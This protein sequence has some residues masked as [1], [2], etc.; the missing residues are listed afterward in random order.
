MVPPPGWSELRCFFLCHPF[1]KTG[2]L[3]RTHTYVDC[4][5]SG[6]ALLSAIPRRGSNQLVCTISRPF[7]IGNGAIW[8]HF[9]LEIAQTRSHQNPSESVAHQNTLKTKYFLA[10]P[11][12]VRLRRNSTEFVRIRQNS[13]EFVG[14][15]RGT[16]RPAAC[17][18]CI[19]TLAWPCLCELHSSTHWRRPLSSPRESLYHGTSK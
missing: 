1:L 5:G 10:P 3:G 16:F 18:Y 8:V 17:Q 9:Q 19:S 11:L 15:R 14:T 7:P 13:S 6:L 4:H 12:F 2:D